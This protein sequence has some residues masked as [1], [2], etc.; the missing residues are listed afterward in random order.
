MRVLTACKECKRPY[1]VSGMTVGSRFHCVC[2]EVLEVPAIKARD[3]AVVRCH[4]CGGPREGDAKSCRYCGADFTLHDQN[5]Q[6]ICP[7]CMT[8]VSDKSRYCHYCAKPFVTVA[9]S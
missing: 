4:A 1:D 7:N 5:L 9:T 8:R 2:G 6:T 3:A